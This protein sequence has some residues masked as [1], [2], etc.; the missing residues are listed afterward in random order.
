MPFDLLAPTLVGVAL[1]IAAG[2]ALSRLLGRND[3]ADTLWGLG[4]ILIAGLHLVQA[5]PP[6]FRA[7]LVLVLVLLW[8]IRLSLHIGIR[9]SGKPEDTR[10]ANWRREWGAAEPVRS[11][12]QVFVLQGVVMGLVSLPLVWAIRVPEAPLT[13]WAFLGISLFVIGFV[14]EAVAD[15]HLARFRRDPA[16]HGKVLRHGVW[17]LSRHPNYF[18]EILV[19]WGFF[20]LAVSLPFGAVTVVS[21]LLMT[22]LLIRVSGVPMLEKVMADR[23]DAYR[24]Y[25]GTTPALL[26]FRAH[27]A[28]RF[29]AIVAALVVLDAV[30]LGYLMRGFYVAETAGVTRMV[31]GDWDVLVWAAAGVYLFLALGIQFFATRPDDRLESLFRGALLG[32]CVYG[33]YEFTNL[34][35]VDGWPLRMALVDVAWGSL[36]CGISAVAGTLV[37]SPGRERSLPLR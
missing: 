30:W 37:Q 8:G 35:L 2:Y 1:F 23:G 20:F 27:A 15:A 11:F 14:F 24:D 16:N 6:G 29:L 34:A 25:V 13:P 9:S 19:W 33:V 36:L 10:Y 28:I 3:V 31:N 18:G 17:S 21:P 32:L 5:G 12:F 22:F 7:T 4:F 26:P